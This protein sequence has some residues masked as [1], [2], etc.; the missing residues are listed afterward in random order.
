MSDPLGAGY[1][2]PTT[3]YYLDQVRKYMMANKAG[4]S[5]SNAYT[6]LYGVPISDALTVTDTATATSLGAPGGFM[7]TDDDAFQK[8]WLP[9]ENDV[10][11]ASGNKNDGTLTGTETYVTS[12]RPYI[13]SRYNK[14][15]DFGAGKITYITA[16]NETQFDFE[17][18]S[19]FSVSFWFKGTSNAKYGLVT[20]DN[21]ETT[22][23]WKVFLNSSG[24][25][26]VRLINTATTNEIDK[27]FNKVITFGSL[28]P[29]II[30]KTS[31]SNAAGI[32]MYYDGAEVTDV[33][34][35]TDNLSATILNNNSVVVGAFGGGG[36][37]L[38]GVLDDV[39]IWNI[40]L[41]ATQ[42]SKLSGGLQISHNASVTQPGIVLE[43]DVT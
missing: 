4:S 36:S 6:P 33:T 22:T 41:S 3:A 16:A 13:D 23:G 15:G 43:S 14:G 35:T 32:K 34:V 25:I 28:H 39:Q 2:E 18:T 10:L 8:L 26:Q 21:G 24:K 5:A 40:T 31:A 12:I 29:I 30:T 27:T 42:I 7:I 1:T 38:T 17:R 37:N 19:T 9:L 20:K 11:D